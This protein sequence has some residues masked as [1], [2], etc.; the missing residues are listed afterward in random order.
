MPTVDSMAMIEVGYEVTDS[1]GAKGR[2]MI[3]GGNWAG[4]ECVFEF[5]DTLFGLLGTARCNWRHTAPRLEVHAGDPS[6]PEARAMLQKVSEMLLP[7]HT[8]AFRDVTD[9]EL[10]ALYAGDYHR[11]QNY[12]T[13]S[14][15]ETNFK[16][17]FV[18]LLLHVTKPR[19]VLDA[20][21]SAGEVVRQLRERGV[22]AWGFDLCRDLDAIAYPEVAPYLRQ[23]DMA[24]IPF[25]PEDGFDTVLA[26]DV[27]EHLPEHRI[28]DML[29]EFVRL[30][31]KRVLARIAVCEFQYE[32]HITLRPL[33]WWDEQLQPFFR[34]R[35][36][37]ES[38][39]HTATVMNAT[40]SLYLVIYELVETPTVVMPQRTTPMPAHV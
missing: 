12:A 8:G 37:R 30:G 24:A 16:R 25:G 10:A 21:C 14:D 35:S 22:D 33:T 17:A 34:R 13:N 19:K 11:S 9:A 20:G 23:G 4:D 15:F 6:Q 7:F 40:P 26:L 27:F 31:V 1:R 2:L 3:R 18:N 38:C 28:A 36:E 5:T 29:A 32:G 39:A